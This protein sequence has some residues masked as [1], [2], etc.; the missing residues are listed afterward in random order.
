MSEQEEKTIN[1]QAICGNCAYWQKVQNPSGPVEIGAPSRGIC[2]A[3]PP[4]PVPRISADGRLI[5]QGHVRPQPMEAET[6]GQF[7]PHPDLTKP[8]GAAN[9]P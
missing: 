7:F 9:D 8:E 5:G 6:C 1:I 4:T 2:V 3:F